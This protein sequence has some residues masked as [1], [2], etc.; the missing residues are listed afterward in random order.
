MIECGFKRRELGYFDLEFYRTNGTEM[1]RQITTI[2]C[3]APMLE[4]KSVANAVAYYR[5]S[6]GFRICF[7]AE[8]E[9]L[10]TYGVVERDGFEVHFFE[11]ALRDADEVRSGST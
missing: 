11:D 8:S 5:D 2:R 7:V 6:L 3:L 4:V 1:D 10:R 9:L